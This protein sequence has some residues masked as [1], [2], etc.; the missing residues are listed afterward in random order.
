MAQSDFGTAQW[1]GAITQQEARL[2]QGRN[3][4]G[5]KLKEPA[6]RQA[7]AAVHPLAD[8]SIYLRRNVRLHNA[9]RQAT[10]FICG[11]GFYELTLNGQKVGD[12]EFAP[13]WSDYD[14][15]VFYN[16]Y[17]VTA[18]L[19]SPCQQPTANSQ[20]LCVL[21]GNGFYN[22]QGKRYAKMKVAFGPPTLLFRLHIE[23]QNGR[24]EDVVS[25]ASWQW[26][27]SPVTF[28]SIYG[29]E[30]YDAQLEGQKD[31]HPVVIQ[32]APRGVLRR[33]IAEPVKLMERYGVKDTVRHDSVLVLDMGQNLSGFPE[34]TVQGRAGQWLKLTPGETLTKDG[35]VNQKQTGRPHYYI[36]TLRGNS[37]KLTAKSQEP[38]VWHPRFS[39]YGYRYLQVEGDVEVLKK[40]ESCFVYNSA[41]KTGA[42]ECSNQLLNDAYRIIDRAIRSNWQSVWTDCPHREKLGWLEQDWLNG[43]GLVSNY[44]CRTMIEQTMQQIADAQFPCGALP[45]IAPNLCVFEGSWAPPFLESPEWGGAF[46]ALPFLYRDYYGDDR[47]VARYRPAM[48]RYVDYLHTQDSCYILKQGL[49]DWYDFGPGRAGFAQNTPMPLVST[50]HYYWWN[51]LMQEPRADSI[52]TAFIREFYHPDT[53]WFGTGSQCAQAMA[54]E[55]DL[56]PDGD[57][58]AVLQQLVA[59]IYAHGDRLTT[60]DVGNRYLFNAL[61]HNGQQELLY[62]MLNHYDVPGYGYQIRLGHTTL[63]EQWNPEHGASMNHFMMGHLNNL[64]VPYILGIWQHDGRVTIAP[65]PLGDLTWCRGE[66]Q[67]VK[68]SWQ[69]KG[70]SFV[71][72]VD[73]PEGQT[74]TVTLPLSGRQQVL[75]SGHT[76]IT[77][78]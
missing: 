7:W 60:G 17:D 59:D 4:T 12:A 13:H 8:R 25:D 63:T 46:I 57:R 58:E 71:L 19:S 1:I 78:D 6:V 68:V 16:T 14:K 32:E 35:L 44:D 34:I 45:E 42:F 36:Y 65:H 39:Y 73:I 66:S 22:E 20:T 38:E 76:Q 3:F 52:R 54:L 29:G 49:G 75:G 37:H 10:V 56:V 67:G 2:P 15:T 11:L 9:V 26:T 28:N 30:D 23:Y 48:K 50:A 74:A 51:K 31:W 47:I 61:I 53:H 41:R 62:K 70:D 27:P 64:L 77:D 43:E 33:Q 18:L 21:L 40:V 72:D 69:R 5:A 24:T 55:M